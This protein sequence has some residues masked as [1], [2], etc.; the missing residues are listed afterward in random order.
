MSGAMQR[1]SAIVFDAYMSEELLGMR[2]SARLTRGTWRDG[3][4]SHARVVNKKRFEI[5]QA[6]LDLVVDSHL[7]GV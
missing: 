4:V 1:L 2:A 3:A 7:R 6:I 5:R